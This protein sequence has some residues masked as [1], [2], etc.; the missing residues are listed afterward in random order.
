M[1]CRAST[2]ISFLR[3]TRCIHLSIRGEV[4]R[5]AALQGNVST[6]ATL[7][8]KSVSAT[9]RKFPGMVELRRADADLDHLIPNVQSSRSTHRVREAL[10][11]AIIALFIKTVGPLAGASFH[12]L[13]LMPPDSSYSLAPEDMKK[14][15]G[16]HTCRVSAAMLRPT[17]RPWRADRPRAQG[18]QLVMPARAM[19]RRSATLRSTSPPSSRRLACT[20]STFAM[21]APSSRWRAKANS[22][23]LFTPSAC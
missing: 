5:G 15:G 3:L 20:M 10:S 2:I 13:G 4:E 14:F 17:Q 1:S 16:Y 23:C 8:Q 18:L 9:L 7:F 11:L 6:P 19:C 22:N 21:P 12:S